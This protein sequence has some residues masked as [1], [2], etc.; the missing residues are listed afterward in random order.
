MS[1]NL[2]RPHQP[3]CRGWARRRDWQQCARASSPLG[4]RARPP[5]W[6][7]RPA[8]RP[9]SRTQRGRKRAAA[10][11]RGGCVQGAPAAA[12]IG[13]TVAPSRAAR[14][15]PRAQPAPARSPGT[16][17]R[18]KEDAQGRDWSPRPAPDP[19]RAG[20][21]PGRWRR[22]AGALSPPESGEAGPAP[23]RF[24]RPRPSDPGPGAGRPTRRPDR[25]GGTFSRAMK[26]AREN[27]PEPIETFPAAGVAAAAPETAA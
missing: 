24:P 22:G 26:K 7:P 13:C 20:I 2:P 10:G 12:P 5:V 1:L 27:Q 23:I 4:T 9:L 14:P 21:K 8:A 25:P 16:G 3:A 19:E 17:S 11:P 18:W 15:P 6:V